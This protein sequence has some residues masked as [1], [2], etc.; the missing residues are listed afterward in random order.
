MKWAFLHLMLLAGLLSG[1]ASTA[2]SE[3]DGVSEETGKTDL[4]ETDLAPPEDVSEEVQ[5]EDAPALDLGQLARE[6]ARVRD[7]ARAAM[8]D[9]GLVSSPRPGTSCFR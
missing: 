6:R 1:C 7:A 4:V 9:H 3:V 2:V 5:S 8:A